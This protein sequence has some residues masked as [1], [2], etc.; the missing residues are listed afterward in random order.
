LIKVKVFDF[1]EN[2]NDTYFGTKEVC[3]LAK[4]IVVLPN[5]NIINAYCNVLLLSFEVRSTT[6]NQESGALAIG[7]PKQSCKTTKDGLVI[8]NTI[9]I[10]VAD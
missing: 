9:N 4:P 6:S 5:K 3:S 7:L 1:S 10:E 2:K 8:S